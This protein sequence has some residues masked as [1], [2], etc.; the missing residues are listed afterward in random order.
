MLGMWWV[1]AAWGVAAAPSPA[2]NPRRH[3]LI[4]VGPPGDADRQKLL[5]KAVSQLQNTL[6]QSGVL[7]EQIRILFGHGHESWPAAEQDN[8]G[9]TVDAMRESI[10]A[11]DAL[12]VF[13][14]GHGSGSGHSSYL[15]LPGPDLDAAGWADLFAE[16]K[17]QEQVF[18]FTQSAS[19]G[20]IKP[21][22]RP[23]RI[24]ISA[25]NVTGEVN[26]PQFP[27][28]LADV[29]S[30]EQASA[31]G[32]RRTVLELFNAV[33]RGVVNY[34]ESRELVATEHPQLDDNGD[35]LGT[36]QPEIEDSDIQPADP[37]A[38]QPDGSLAARTAWKATV[39]FGGD[40]PPTNTA[41]SVPNKVDET[42]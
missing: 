28:V 6:E 35:G 30:S 21:F 11:D 4:V 33:R 12:W 16:W 24:V 40:D 34:Y 41:K 38:T 42:Q 1:A 39:P 27:Q 14:F 32:D 15:H 18:W 25:T 19:G 20:F 2:H 17:C 5:G 26:E 36:E 31:D 22:S 7:S 3:V 10:Q 8:L 29:L 37:L 13:V 9:Q 23:G